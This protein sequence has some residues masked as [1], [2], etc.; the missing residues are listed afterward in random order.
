MPEKE[1][2]EK[3]TR[4]DIPLTSSVIIDDF[5]RAA[6]KAFDLEF[7]GVSKFYPWNKPETL[8]KDF[9]LGVIYGGSGSGK[10]KLLKEFGNEEIIEWEDNKAI[11]SHFDTPDDGINRLSAVGLNSIPAWHKQYSVLSNGEQFRADLAR[12]IKNNAVI[13]EFTSVVDRNVAKAASTALSKYIKNTNLHGIVLATC[14]EDILDW[15]QPDWVINTNTG[16]IYDGFFLS[17]RQSISK[18]IAAITIRGACLKNIII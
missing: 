8:K 1:I 15:L 6:S 7:N 5:T 9:K 10:T 13:D 14:H 3:L 16:E 11:I 4:N 17:A 18:Y 2:I 12:R